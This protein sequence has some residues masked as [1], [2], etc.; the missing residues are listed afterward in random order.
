MSTQR[1]HNQRKSMTRQLA[2]SVAAVK[3][4]SCGLGA[5]EAGLDMYGVERPT[6][7]GNQ[8]LW[9][10]ASQGNCSAQSAILAPASLVS[11]TIEATTILLPADLNS[12]ADSKRVA[13]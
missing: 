4:Q 9:A 1:L 2:I 8:G 5:F 7:S 11:S 10:L 13:T 3:H 6:G 12:P